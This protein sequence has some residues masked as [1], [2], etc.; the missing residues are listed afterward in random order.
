[1]FLNLGAIFL[2]FMEEDSYI[3]TAVWYGRFIVISLIF[4]SLFS[5]IVGAA[6]IGYGKYPFV[7]LNLM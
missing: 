4:L 6:L 3:E 2:R 7:I 1:M 5:Q